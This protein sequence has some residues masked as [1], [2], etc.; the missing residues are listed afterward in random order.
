[1]Q[2]IIEL[3]LK[4]W[5]TSIKCLLHFTSV[6]V[7]HL[8]CKD[9]KIKMDG[10]AY[11][12]STVVWVVTPTSFIFRVEVQAHFLAW[13][14]FDPE[15]GGNMFLRNVGLSLLTAH[16]YNLEDRAFHTHHRENLR[17]N[18]QHICCTWFLFPLLLTHV[19]C[20]LY[21]KYDEAKHPR[22]GMSVCIPNFE[23]VD[24]ISINFDIV[25]L[26]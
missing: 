16:R 17:F 7:R 23:A 11:L 10:N 26:H 1:M 18:L 19:L 5:K 12:K 21:T 8:T 6:N 22:G 24:R 3:A 13:L 25:G 15:N 20:F 2:F 4:S 14:T 9:I